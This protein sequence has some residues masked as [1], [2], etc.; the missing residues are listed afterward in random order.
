MRIHVG[1]TNQNKVGAVE[2]VVRIIP[3]LS[4]AEIV[5]CEVRSGVS[6]Q[7]MDLAETV[8]GATNRAKAAFVGADLG[9]GLEG[10]IMEVPGAGRMNVQVC[11]VFD[12][13]RLH[14]GLS[15]AFSLPSDITALMEAKNLELDTAVY[16]LGYVKTK[17]VGKEGGLIGILSGGHLTRRDLCKQAV[18]VTM[19][20]FYAGYKAAT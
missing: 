18:E 16:D 11:A 8:R 15:S 4:Q 19:I 10:G 9:V 13:V 2:D 7:P 5:G 14:H 1:S 20:H 12:G 3:V 6:D 17:H